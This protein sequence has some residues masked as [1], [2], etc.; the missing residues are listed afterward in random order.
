MIRM[1][2]KP[3]HCVSSRRFVWCC[4]SKSNE[5][6]NGYE[7]NTAKTNEYPFLGT[8]NS[9]QITNKLFILKCVRFHIIQLL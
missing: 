6:V 8:N 9:M 2:S 3:L 7:N 4:Y 5:Y 1:N